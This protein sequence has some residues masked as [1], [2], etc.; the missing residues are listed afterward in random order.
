M[1]LDLCGS[2]V[3][4]LG[5]QFLRAVQPLLILGWAMAR[6]IINLASGLLQLQAT[7]PQCVCEEL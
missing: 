3:L 1:V 7:V 5:S 4:R 6:D 2:K